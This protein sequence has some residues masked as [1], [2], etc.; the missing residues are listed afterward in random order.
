MSQ[1][2]SRDGR[3]ILRLNPATLEPV[4]R[5]L[6]TYL[7][8][9]PLDT[10]KLIPVKTFVDWVH[11]SCQPSPNLS[12]PATHFDSPK[13]A[14]DAVAVV[15]D[16]HSPKHVWQLRASKDASLGQLSDWA[17][18]CVKELQSSPYFQLAD[19]E[20]TS[21]TILDVLFCDRLKRLRDNEAEKHLN[22][23][24]EVSLSVQSKL[25]NLLIQGRADW[26]LA[27][28]DSKAALQT[29]LVVLEAKKSGMAQTALPQL[30]IY[31]AAVQDSR[32]SSRKINSSIF[33]LIS[34]SEDYRFAWL[35]ENRHLFVSETFSW[36]TKKAE[37]V[38][39]IDR[40]LRDSIEA[41]PHTTPTKTGNTAVHA[42]R[43]HISREYK[44]GDTD[45]IEAVEGEDIR[46]YR[47]VK[48]GPY[49]E[50]IT[51]METCL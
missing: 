31:L 8:D 10:E 50:I 42:Y 37:I 47:I 15:Y 5:T 38:E 44:L 26:C 14:A 13:S 19:S 35:D 21:R 11:E 7:E 23:F 12:V 3:V 32:K 18:T 29:A 1:R 30:I 24:P 46:Q 49:G 25:H 2:T 51:E 36:V 22:W 48:K 45:V 40:I 28:W 34:D 33:G 39:W 9:N 16:R 6:A 41:S 17:D 43:N 20:S 4:F 27:Y